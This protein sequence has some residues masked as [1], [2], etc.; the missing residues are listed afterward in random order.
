MITHHPPR[1]D[2][3]PCCCADLKIADQQSN[4]NRPLL[5]ITSQGGLLRARF[6]RPDLAGPRRNTG[7]RGPVCG[8]SKRSR[9]RMLEK[10][11]C[12][13]WEARPEDCPTPN[14]TM[15]RLI[16]LT[17]PYPMEDWDEAKAQLRS[18]WKRLRR[19]FEGKPR[20]AQPCGLWR[21]E[22]H[23]PGVIHHHLLILCP[24]IDHS[25][26]HRQW[27]Q[28]LGVEEGA[29][30]HIKAKPSAKVAKVAGK[31]IA[32]LDTASPSSSL[33]HMPY[34]AAD[35]VRTGRVW[36]LMNTQYIPWAPEVTFEVPLGPWFWDLKRLARRKWPGV[37]GHRVGFMLF[38]E[39][40]ADWLTWLFRRLAE[41]GFL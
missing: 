20:W 15:W 26:L 40:P 10:I 12:I 31:Y 3:D 38:T 8:L 2:T 9:H 16:T 22:D 32:K 19:H 25:W 35:P 30:V 5:H 7:T 6:E 13:D 29:W 34:R 1:R 4:A 23:R 28:V 11:S 14:A 33:D 39:A 41:D 24:W 18:L 17:Y 27:Q 37:R 36:G 21:I